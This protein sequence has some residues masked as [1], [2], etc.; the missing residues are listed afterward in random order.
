MRA[1]LSA[2]ILLLAFFVVA[3]Q[4]HSEW[5]VFRSEAD[6]FSIEMPD[7]PKITNRDLGSGAS[8]KFFQVEVRQEAYLA[9]VIQ[10]PA[11]K[12]PAS[13]DEAY[14]S[15]LLKAYCEG[16]G[17]K[18]RSSRMITWAGHNALEGIAD[19]ESAVHLIDMTAAGDRLDLVVSS[20]A[21]GQESGPR[22]THMR[23]SFQ[24]LSK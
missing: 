3:A 18:L 11:G 4:Q 10:L 6:G 22:A 16:S 5:Q 23:D 12:G 19:S 8:Q 1:L 7:S 17:T 14:F 13:P 24:L 20:V 9:S 2:A 15:K 21:K